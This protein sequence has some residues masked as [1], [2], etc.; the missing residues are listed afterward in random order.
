[1]AEPD[2]SRTLRDTIT[3]DAADA[4]LLGR[5]LAD[6]VMAAGAG[7]LLERLRTG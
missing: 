4:A 5:Q 3:G 6:R 1:V 2:G 7:T